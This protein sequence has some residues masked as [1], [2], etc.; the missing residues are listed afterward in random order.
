MAKLKVFL[1]MIE[2]PMSA[3]QQ[4]AGPM[5]S[6]YHNWPRLGVDDHLRVCLLEGQREVARCT[7]SCGIDACHPIGG[8]TGK[9][10]PKSLLHLIATM[11][12]IAP[13]AL[14]VVYSSAHGDQTV[15]SEFTRG[16]LLGIFPTV[17]FFAV[18]LLR[19]STEFAPR[20]PTGAELRGLGGG[21]LPAT[22]DA[23]AAGIVDR[24]VT[25][26]IGRTIAAAPSFFSA[27]LPPGSLDWGTEMRLGRPLTMSRFV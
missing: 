21:R 20:A 10:Q 11:P 4:S 25:R 19:V 5:S 9:A 23:E 16:M 17:A 14:W 26:R 24:S 15:V 22:R 12:M 1:G 27:I 6:S 13:Q 8:A 3:C 2:W 18:A 7:P